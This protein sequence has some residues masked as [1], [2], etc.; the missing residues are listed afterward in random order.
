M[1]KTALTILVV[2]AFIALIL[3]ILGLADVFY[4]FNVTVLEKIHEFLLSF[5]SG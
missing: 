4:S 1:K 3:W 2:S 5:F